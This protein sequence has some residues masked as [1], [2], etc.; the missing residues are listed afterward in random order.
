M[1]VGSRA[2]PVRSAAQRPQPDQTPPGPQASLPSWRPEVPAPLLPPPPSPSVEELRGGET[3]LQVLELQG[4]DPGNVKELRLLR[5][6]RAAA[7][8]KESVPRTEPQ[9]RHRDK[10]KSQCSCLWGPP[11]ERKSFKTLCLGGCVAARRMWGRHMGRLPGPGT[12]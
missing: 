11:R 10:P 7:Q 2:G 9:P 1:A 3:H 5:A 12:P 4:G 8:Q 6:G